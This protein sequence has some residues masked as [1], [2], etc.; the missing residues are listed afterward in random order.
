MKM[1]LRA[2]AHTHTHTHS[3]TH[4]H[5][6]TRPRKT[7]IPFL[8]PLNKVAPTTCMFVAANTHF[9]GTKFC[10]CNPR[11]VAANIDNSGVSLA[12]GLNVLRENDSVFILYTH[13]CCRVC[14]KWK[15][16]IYIYIYTTGGIL[17]ETVPLVE[18][19]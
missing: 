18:T 17:C 14:L 19:V 2:R 11:I 5:T 8:Q 10:C 3:H 6:H 9:P 7:A 4:T 15:V 1:L 12:Q 13:L 16:Y